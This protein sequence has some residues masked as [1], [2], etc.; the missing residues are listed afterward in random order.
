LR[1]ERAGSIGRLPISIWLQIITSSL[2]LAI[3]LTL[4][5]IGGATS[6]RVL[7]ATKWA[8]ASQGL[9]SLGRLRPS[10]A[11]IPKSST[12]SAITPMK[13]RLTEAP[14]CWRCSVIVRCLRRHAISLM[15]LAVHASL[16][17]IRTPSVVALAIPLLVLIHVCS[18]IWARIIRMTI[19]V[20][21]RLSLWLR[22]MCLLARGG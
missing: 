7:H 1:E 3:M 11:I 18:V 9:G 5:L 10:T 17:T 22:R 12:K 19:R 21:A 4:T 2:L 20:L 8:T 14:N 15:G 16:C 13:R 6:K